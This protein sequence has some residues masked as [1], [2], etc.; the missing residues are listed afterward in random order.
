MPRIGT[1][2]AEG[3]HGY[4]APIAGTATPVGR[5]GGHRTGRPCAKRPDGPLESLQAAFAQVFDGHDK[6]VGDLIANGGRDDDLVRT[7]QVAQPRGKIDAVAVDVEFVGEHVRDVRAHAQPDPALQIDGSLAANRA[8]LHGQRALDRRHGA[9]E[10]GEHAVALQLHAA[11]PELRQVHRR[12]RRHQF[13]P[14]R[15]GAASSRLMIRTE[16]TMSTN[17]T[18]RRRRVAS[19]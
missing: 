15:N 11:S 9:L 3:K 13:P 12:D 4:R 6:S 14:T 19:A 8:R 2:A 17:S 18:A 7:A 16:S 1:E 10:F 5:S